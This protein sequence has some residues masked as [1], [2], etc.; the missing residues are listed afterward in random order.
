MQASSDI[1]G[2]L[3]LVDR[4]DLAGATMHD[5]APFEPLLGEAG[6][7]LLVRAGPYPSPA[8]DFHTE[9][10]QAALFN[11]CHGRPQKIDWQWAALS[12]AGTSGGDCCNGHVAPLVRQNSLPK[13]RAIDEF[14]SPFQFQQ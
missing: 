13:R 2:L 9:N 4:D 10:L 14:V 8:S 6:V 5:A 11:R 3:E 1:A 12:R 7:V